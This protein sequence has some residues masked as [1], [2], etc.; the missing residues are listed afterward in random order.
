MGGVVWWAMGERKGKAGGELA[1]KTFGRRGVRS[2][3][4]AERRGQSERHGM[5]WQC[6]YQY[7][8]EGGCI[9]ACLQ[10]ERVCLVITHR[11]IST[12]HVLLFFHSS[13]HDF[14]ST[15]CPSMLGQ[16]KRKEHFRMRAVTIIDSMW[17][18]K[19]NVRAKSLSSLMLLHPQ[20]GAKAKTKKKRITLRIAPS[21]SSQESYYLTLFISF[22][23]LYRHPAAHPV[24]AGV[25][26]PIP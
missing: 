25:L 16:A 24:A 26:H 19:E 23:L 6:V 18:N 4:G 1:E 21:L 7:G 9:K 5:A 3:K 2:E 15:H 20:G 17:T 11:L 8:A 14:L 10:V 12:Q 22:V 13:R